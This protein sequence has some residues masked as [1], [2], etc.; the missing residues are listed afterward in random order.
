MDR[1][2]AAVITNKREN[3][4]QLCAAGRPEVKAGVFVLVV[5][6]HRMFRRVLDVLVGDSVLS[7]RRMDIH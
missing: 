3:L 6:R 4:E 2:L 1:K 5:N 7:R